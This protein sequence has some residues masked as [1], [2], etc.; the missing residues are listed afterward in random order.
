[1]DKKIPQLTSIEL[2]FES[3]EEYESFLADLQQTPI[4][5]EGKSLQLVRHD[6]NMMYSSRKVAVILTSITCLT[7]LA[8]S[9]I[10]NL[11]RLAEIRSNERMHTLT[12]TAQNG[13]PLM[14]QGQ[15]NKKAMEALNNGDSEK[16]LTD[17]LDRDV[18]EKIQSLRESV[19]NNDD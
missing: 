8:T 12:I 6:N 9:V 17:T 1:M 19:N 18:Q 7:P 11:V 10:E 4:V 2:R 13:Y 5:V 16:L 14:H 15:V 3:E